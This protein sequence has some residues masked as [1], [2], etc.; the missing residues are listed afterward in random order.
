MPRINF[1][2][3]E[4]I[5]QIADNNHLRRSQSA[6]REEEAEQPMD[7]LRTLLSPL[8]FGHSDLCV[9][10]FA[11]DFKPLISSRHTL[12]LPSL[13]LGVVTETS[14]KERPSTRVTEVQ[15]EPGQEESVRGSG[16]ISSPFSRWL[17]QR[18]GIVLVDTLD[19]WAPQKIHYRHTQRS[20]WSLSQSV[21]RSARTVGEKWN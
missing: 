8:P 18:E 2:G 12:P 10:G 15:G 6:T 11:E 21:T 9:N 17:H 13:L 1:T 16:S 20:L 19:P 7:P 4:I 14:G 5:D 3:S